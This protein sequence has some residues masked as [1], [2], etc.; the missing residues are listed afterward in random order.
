MTRSKT[1]VKS[2]IKEARH[3]RSLL[4]EYGLKLGG[5]NPG[6]LAFKPTGRFDYHGRPTSTSI[7][8]DRRVWDFI[9]PLLIELRAYRRK[10]KR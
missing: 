10:A 1:E 7:D 6:V 4:K 2:I 3:L 9:E 5:W 8:F